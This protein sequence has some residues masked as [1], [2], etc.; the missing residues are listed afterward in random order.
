MTAPHN[1]Y[2][3]VPFCMSK[4]NYCAF[5]SRAC[6]AP[7]WDAY[8]SGIAKEINTWGERLGHIDVPTVFFGGGTP[9]LMPI[10]VFEKIM[11]A[12]RANFNLAQDA[13]ITLESNPGTLDTAKLH[14]FISLGVNRLSVGV[15]S[16]DD[17]RLRFLGRRHSAYDAKKLLDAA[18]ACNI[19]VSGDFIYG[20]PGDTVRDVIKT[21][22]QINDLNLTHCSMYELT[23][24]ENTPFGKMNLDMPSNDEMADMY[25][26][27]ADNLHIPR[28]EVSNYATTGNECRHNQNVWDGAPYIGIGMGAAGRVYMNNTW[29]E[30]RGANAEFTPMTERDRAIEKAITGMRTMRGLKLSPDVLGIINTDFINAHPELIT[31]TADGRIVATNASLL[32]LDDLMVQLIG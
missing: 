6:N 28:Y 9:S 27:I 14:E 16:F 30:Q 24:E 13:E 32:I 22:R 12:L 3:H 20:L 19:R 29:Y 31:Q 1:I 18:M 5:F 26:A 11:I 21:C 23:I 4:C 15:Q 8:V 10:A 2:I 7:D 25:C 17:A